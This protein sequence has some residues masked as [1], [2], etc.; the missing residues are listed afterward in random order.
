MLLF[1]QNL[2]QVIKISLDI[3][4][5]SETKINNKVLIIIKNKLKKQVNVILI[6]INSQELSEISIISEAIFTL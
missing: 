4:Y 3:F 6:F 5:H 1:I 2:P